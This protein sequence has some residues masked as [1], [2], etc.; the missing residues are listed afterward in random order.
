MKARIK[1]PTKARTKARIKA[2]GRAGTAVT[3]RAALP[4]WL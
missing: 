2:Q 1:A 4:S 3:A